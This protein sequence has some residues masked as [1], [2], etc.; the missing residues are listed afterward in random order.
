MIQGM[1]IF[2]ASN[3]FLDAWA[4]FPIIWK[5]NQDQEDSPSPFLFF[6]FLYFFS[7][8]FFLSLFFFFTH[9]LKVL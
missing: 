6:F 1:F 8:F 7:L 5:D 9:P 3:R 2:T 4:T